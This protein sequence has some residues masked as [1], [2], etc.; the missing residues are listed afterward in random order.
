MCAALLLRFLF[1]VAGSAG[2]AGG[3]G[4]GG[5]AGTFTI[6]LTN[7]LTRPRHSYVPAEEKKV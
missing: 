1:E 6:C 5:L 3:A 7:L 2:G 4:G